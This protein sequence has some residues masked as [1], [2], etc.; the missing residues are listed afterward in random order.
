MRAASGAATAPRARVL[1]SEARRERSKA[2]DH[3]V[4]C[5]HLIFPS[6]HARTHCRRRAALTAMPSAFPEPATKRECKRCTNG[7]V[8]CAIEVCVLALCGAC[9]RWACKAQ[10]AY[11]PRNML[12]RFLRRGMSSTLNADAQSVWPLT[13]NDAD[14]NCTATARRHDTPNPDQR[15]VA[16]LLP[17]ARCGR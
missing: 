6:R 16:N 7:L 9:G 14:D 3:A 11:P 10:A 12:M 17:R 15:S 1:S 5:E 4:H 8:F 2:C 13:T